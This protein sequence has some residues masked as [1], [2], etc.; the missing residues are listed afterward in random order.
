MAE[1]RTCI[2][3]VAFSAS[4]EQ[5][6]H[7]RRL[8]LKN[9]LTLLSTAALVLMTSAHAAERLPTIPPDKYDVEQAKAAQDFQAARKVPVFGP[10]EPLMHSP[11]VMSQTRA[12]GDYL[13]Y[14]SAIGNTLSELVILITAREWSQDYEWYVHHPI[15]LKAGI[16]PSIADAIA[17]GRRPTGMS[18]DEEIVYDFTTELIRNKRV[19]DG[20]YARAEKRFGNKGIVDMTGICGYYTLLAMEMNVAQYPVPKNTAKLARFPEH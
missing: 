16:K 5:S 13:R 18:D 4:K 20:T 12:M 10:F 8:T 1:R 6:K 14:H 2:P 11:E 19:A 17:D 9:V 7:M 3:A 15:A